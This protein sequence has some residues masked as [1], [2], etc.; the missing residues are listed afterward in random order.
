MT[1]QILNIFLRV[2]AVAVACL[3]VW[4]YLTYTT[5]R[6]IEYA[7]EDRDKSKTAPAAEKKTP[8]ETAS[9]SESDTAFTKFDVEVAIRDFAPEWPCFRGLARD[10][11]VRD[12]VPLTK[13][14]G[15]SGPKVLWRVP[16]GEG[17]SGA[18]IVGG[19]VYVLDY[20]E[21]DSSDALRCFELF[22]GTELWRRGYR[23][24]IR[25]NHGKSRTI[26]AYSD[27]VVVT[28]GPATHVM[29]VDAVSGDLLW[30]RNIVETYG[31]EI[32]L[33]YAG[34]CPLIEDGK[35]ILGIGGDKVLMTALDLRTGETVW[36]MPNDHGMKMSHSSVLS[37]ELLGTKQYVY[38]GI[39]GVA[40][41]DRQGNPL[42]TCTK[43]KPAVWAP[44]PLAI[45]DERLFLTAGYAAGGAVLAVKKDGD[46]FAAE[47]EQEW[48]PT[49]GPASE[50]QTPILLGDTMFVIQPKDAGARHAEFI[51]ADVSAL[52][53]IKAE[54]GKDARFGLGPYL[55]ADGAFWIL[56][57][58]GV[59]YVY[60][61]GGDG[62][63]RLAS[64][65]ILPGTDSWG[66]IALAAGIMI[67]RDS[68]SMVCLDL[69][70]EVQP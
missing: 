21:E 3:G 27:G 51:A 15:E 19:R 20:V 26:P 18:I 41:C 2:F 49:K 35:V 64:H 60:E 38:A 45:S 62:F 22:S 16:L 68:T 36:E 50:Q 53:A 9:F 46:R 10:N 34:Q 13:D 32:P 67:L 42:W 69:R 28:L 47:I 24:P 29:A 39:G 48:K 63:R 58:E 59:L 33:W 4:H 37:T 23:N 70:K 55:Y 54:S 12:D 8:S 30:T 31:G 14:W 5:P 17:Y 56:D 11:Q 1:A 57:D 40:A 44:T 66:P 25:R 61:Y 7:V 43:W 6:Q 52:P 65:K